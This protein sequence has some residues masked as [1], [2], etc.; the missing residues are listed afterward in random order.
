MVVVAAREKAKAC[1][2]L[3]IVGTSGMKE[4]KLPTSFFILGS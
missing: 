4:I 2:M 3:L 1:Y